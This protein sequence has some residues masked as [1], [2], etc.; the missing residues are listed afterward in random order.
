MLVRNALVE[1]L[2]KNEHVIQ[3]IS[4]EQILEEF[5]LKGIDY[6]AWAKFGSG[7]IA[8]AQDIWLTKTL[9]KEFGYQGKAVI[10]N[11]RGKTYVILK[12]YPG[13]REIFKGTRYL[14]SN[15]QV[16][17]MSVGPKG[18]MK[19]VKGGFVITIVL[20]VGIEVVDYFFNDKRTLH[21]FLGTVSADIVKIGISAILSAVAAS[22]ATGAIGVASAI[23]APLVAAIFVGLFTGY[24]LNKIDDKVGATAELIA[25]YE[26]AGIN[27]N[28]AISAAMKIPHT[29]NRE[30]YKWERSYINRSLNR[31]GIY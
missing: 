9:L 12:G 27:L 3:I 21:D 25:M 14:A 31:A 1:E 23:A 18:I 17:R 4:I 20:S 11:Y 22:A 2:K 13:S 10:K 7:L 30:I 26:R 6:S 24:I 28:Q 5:E 19:S 29:I 15:P 16:V 8:P